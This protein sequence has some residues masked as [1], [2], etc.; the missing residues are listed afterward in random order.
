MYFIHYFSSKNLYRISAVLLSN[1]AADSTGIQYYNNNYYK[2][3]HFYKLA[4]KKE[5][6]H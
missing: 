3:N 6:K 1:V 2:Y 5:K 4:L